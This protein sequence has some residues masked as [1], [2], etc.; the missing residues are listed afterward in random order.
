MSTPNGLSPAQWR[1]LLATAKVIVA[2]DGD[3]VTCARTR[4]SIHEL[5]RHGVREATVVALAARDLL[6]TSEVRI[7]SFVTR[8]SGVRLTVAGLAAL[9]AAVSNADMSTAAAQEAR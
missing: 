5:K 8:L 7:N 9:R 1:A 4:V 2:R 6:H 3:F